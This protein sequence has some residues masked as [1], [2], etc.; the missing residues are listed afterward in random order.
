MRLSNACRILAHNHS[1][2]HFYWNGISLFHNEFI[3]INNQFQLRPLF[4]N[5]LSSR[6]YVPGKR[7]DTLRSISFHFNK[8][9]KQPHFQ[10][11][12]QLSANGHSRKRTALLTV[13]TPFQIPVLPP[14]QTQ[15]LHIPVSGH[16]LVT[17]RG[18]F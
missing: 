5:P 14:N 16:S 8:K 17:R 1:L 2:L 13:R 11:Y 4:R 7:G 3:L 15:Y 10:Y 18:H 12:S 6:L 9:L